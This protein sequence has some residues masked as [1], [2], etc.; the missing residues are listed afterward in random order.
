MHATIKILIPGVNR[1][2]LYLKPK[3]ILPFGWSRA[4]SPKDQIL[5]MRLM[6]IQGTNPYVGL[7]TQEKKIVK[8]RYYFAMLA[9]SII[10][11]LSN[12]ALKL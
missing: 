5:H 8:D 1:H 9:K 7:G 10:L 6:D 4:V 11:E 2:A 12:S 3:L